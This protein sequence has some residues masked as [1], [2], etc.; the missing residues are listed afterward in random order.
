MYT[1]LIWI[2][3][4]KKL[5]FCPFVAIYCIMNISAHIRLLC[6]YMHCT[7]VRT[8]DVL[9]ILLFSFLSPLLI[10]SFS[11]SF[12]SDFSPCRLSPLCFF[13]SALPPQ[14]LLTF[15]SFPLLALSLPL[16]PLNFFLFFSSSLFYWQ[17]GGEEVEEVSRRRVR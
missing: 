4:Y 1:C 6:M 15:S 14:L 12:F 17:F 11:S 7:N 10:L 16:C 8:V 13:S 3:F 9:Y 5:H 2:Y